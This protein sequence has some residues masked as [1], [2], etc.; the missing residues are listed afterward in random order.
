MLEAMI[1]AR[2]EGRV[3]HFGSCAVV[4]ARDDRLRT[5]RRNTRARAVIGYRKTV[6]S[7]L[8]LAAFELLLLEALSRYSQTGAP[9]RHLRSNYKSLCD[10]LGFKYIF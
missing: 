2:A 3:I 1:N 10:K 7:D 4:R 6:Y 5:F 9:A 8:E